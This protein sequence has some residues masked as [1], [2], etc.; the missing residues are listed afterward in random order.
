MKMTELPRPKFYPF[1]GSYI[2][3]F[4]FSETVNLAYVFVG[5][6]VPFIAILIIITIFAVCCHIKRT[7]GKY[8]TSKDKNIN[9][10][11]DT[12]I[13]LEEYARTPD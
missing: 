12:N 13:P 9:N 1:I 7:R 5:C 2:L 6:L 3:S 4:S 10:T 8:E 11:N